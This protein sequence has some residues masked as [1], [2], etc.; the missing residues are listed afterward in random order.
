MG[1]SKNLVDLAEEL[2]E[3]MA[4]VEIEYPNHVLFQNLGEIRSRIYTM[5]AQI[6]NIPLWNKNIEKTNEFYS[7]LNE[8]VGGNK[9]ELVK[10][11]FNHLYDRIGKAPVSFMI[12]GSLIL[13]VPLIQRAIDAYMK[14]MKDENTGRIGEIVIYSP[15]VLPMLT[16]EE[17]LSYR[18]TMKPLYINKDDLN[19]TESELIKHYIN[20]ET[21]IHRR[22]NQA[23]PGQ[24]VQKKF[25]H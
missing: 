8:E 2:F 25:I 17:L 12:R 23:L 22:E 15:E 20:V 1:E 7:V 14:S 4:S 16:I 10:L 24:P 9:E 11:A 21:E 3:F 5:T 19:D 18:D 13:I 6:D